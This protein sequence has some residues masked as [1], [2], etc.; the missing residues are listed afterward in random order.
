MEKV[1]AK[2]TNKLK[3]KQK[4]LVRKK[5]V[6]K[7]GNWISLMVAKKYVIHVQPSIGKITF[8]NMDL[9]GLLRSRVQ[10][11]FHKTLGSAMFTATFNLVGVYLP[12]FLEH[13]KD[14][15]KSFN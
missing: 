9:V 11:I 12:W 1:E 3:Q 2:L 8:V 13:L 7:I 15:I 4:Y 5:K 14:G 10:A 6:K